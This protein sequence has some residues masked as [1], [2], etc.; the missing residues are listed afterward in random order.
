MKHL[1]ATL[2]LFCG[3]A[4]AQEPAVLVVDR[5]AAEETLPLLQSGELS[6]AQIKRLLRTD[7]Q[8]VILLRPETLKSLQ[9]HELSKAESDELRHALA[10]GLGRPSAPLRLC[11]AKEL[12]EFARDDVTRFIIL[13]AGSHCRQGP[14]Q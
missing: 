2:I 4:S 1:L 8:L 14:K 5:L 6:R 12:Q 13:P 10:H 3:V 9:V 7:G 11:T